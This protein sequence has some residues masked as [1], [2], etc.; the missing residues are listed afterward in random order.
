MEKTTSRRPSTK[1]ALEVCRQMPQRLHWLDQT[2]PFDIR[3]SH[4]VGWLIRQPEI[5]QFLFDT[6]R[7]RKLIEFDGGCWQ[8]KKR[9]DV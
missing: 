7:N 9:G 6:V 5:L 8:G 3:E 1:A 2:K 4:V